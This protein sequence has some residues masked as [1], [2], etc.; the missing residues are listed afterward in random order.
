MVSGVLKLDFDN[1]YKSKRMDESRIGWVCRFIR[2]DVRDVKAW[3]TKHGT[4]VKIWTGRRLS[5]LMAVMVQA[6]CN[7]DYARECY[8]LVRAINLLDKEKKY[9]KAVSESFNVLF[10][11]KMAGGKV[12]GMEKFDPVATKRLRKC[13]GL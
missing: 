12:V 9:S 10:Y 13:L 2:L 5:P 11:K 8:N 3:K 1:K 7:S 6:L 4:H